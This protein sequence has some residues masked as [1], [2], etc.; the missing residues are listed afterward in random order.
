MVKHMARIETLLYIIKEGNVLLIKKKRGLGSGLYN[1]VGGKVED[2]ELPF[3]AAIRECE[4]EIGVK[5]KNIEW[6]GVLEFIND[7]SVYS[8]VH[9]FVSDGYEGTLKETEEAEP[10]WFPLKNLPYYRMW[11]DDKYWLPL[12]LLERKKIY[13]SFYFKGNW[14]KLIAYKIYTLEEYTRNKYG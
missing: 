2:N 13:A 1:G 11:E 9:I 3:Q 5:P 8:Y 4:E 7:G 10:V 14:A 6:M 12:V